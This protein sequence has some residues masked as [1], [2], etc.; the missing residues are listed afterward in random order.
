VVGN[1]TGYGAIPPAR[2]DAPDWWVVVDCTRPEAELLGVRPGGSKAELGSYLILWKAA[3]QNLKPQPI[4]LFLASSRHGPWL[5]LARGLPNTGSYRWVVPEQLSGEFFLRM[6][7]TDLAGNFGA[8][9]L[10]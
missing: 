3:D 9:E 7:V 10:P 8:S 6:E 2:G 1:V 4:D 5:S